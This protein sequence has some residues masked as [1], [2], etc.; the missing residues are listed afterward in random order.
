MVLGDA[1][2]PGRYPADGKN[3]ISETAEV[4]RVPSSA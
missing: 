4:G 1:V 2:N 3:R